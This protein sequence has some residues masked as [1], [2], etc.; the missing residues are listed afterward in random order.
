MD[1]ASPWKQQYEK[2]KAGMRAD[3]ETV[4]AGLPIFAYSGNAAPAARTVA[5]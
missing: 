4:F 5:A 3:S 1:A 2:A